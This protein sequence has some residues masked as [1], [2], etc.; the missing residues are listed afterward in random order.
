MEIKYEFIEM[1][2]IK[3]NVKFNNFEVINVIQFDENRIFIV[4]KIDGE[5]NSIDYTNKYAEEI[6]NLYLEYDRAANSNE[7]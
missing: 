4:C 7:D 3:P 5:L 2:F 1:L 6:Y